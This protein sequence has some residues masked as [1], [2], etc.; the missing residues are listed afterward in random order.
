MD[1][2]AARAEIVTP[3]QKECSGCHAVLPASQFYRDR[4]R[5]DGLYAN[6]KGCHRRITNG[7]KGRHPIKVRQ[8]DR[9]SKHRNREKINAAARAHHW[10]NRERRLAY[11]AEWKRA[12]RAR[13]T[14]I[15]ATRRA[16]KA[17]APGDATPEHVAARWQ[18]YGNRCWMCGGEATAIDHV[19]PLSAGGSHW[20][21]NLRPACE[22][23]NGSK[24]NLWP[25]DGLAGRLAKTAERRE[26]IG[27]AR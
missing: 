12:N 18:Y 14:A 5:P 19:K 3:D 10:A 24:N 8:I 17:N 20:P 26:Q 25:L 6:C 9:A 16:R 21:A 22:G 15:E 23:C 11:T 2:N 27:V 13:A 4:R 1:K 7:W